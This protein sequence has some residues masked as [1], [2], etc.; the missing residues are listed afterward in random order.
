VDYFKCD[1]AKNK[2]LCCKGRNVTLEVFVDEMK[3]F[4]PDKTVFMLFSMG[5]SDGKNILNLP[6]SITNPTFYEKSEVR[7]SEVVGVP[8][9]IRDQDLIR[10]WFPRNKGCYHLGNDNRCTIYNR[11]PIICRVY[12][13]I[14]S[15]DEFSIVMRMVPPEEKLRILKGEKKYLPLYFSKCRE[16]CKEC[17]SKDKKKGFLPL[18][19]LKNKVQREIA[20]IANEIMSNHRNYLEDF[21]RKYLPSYLNLLIPALRNR[22]SIEY[23]KKPEPYYSPILS[24]ALVQELFG[25]EGVKAQVRAVKD[26]L[27]GNQVNDSERTMMELYL[28]LLE[29]KD[30]CESILEKDYENFQKLGT[31]RIKALVEDSLIRFE[32]FRQTMRNHKYKWF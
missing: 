14:N 29:E 2:A 25:E 28:K 12:P 10:V 5:F 21:F 32:S 18:D 1:P 13:F 3:L 30:L 7:I 6:H 11:R 31:D 17:F 23:L 9:S 24:V 20:H 26:L 4:D 15:E 16:C 22:S 27:K 19:K 8:T